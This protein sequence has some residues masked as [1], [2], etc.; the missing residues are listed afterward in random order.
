V[1]EPHILHIT[2][3]FSLFILRRCNEMYGEDEVYLQA[4]L[5]S[6]LDTGEWRPSRLVSFTLRQ[7]SQV[8][9]GQAREQVWTL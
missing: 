4:F 5:T 3:Y 1:S 6:A 7:E 8:P 2:G 9:T